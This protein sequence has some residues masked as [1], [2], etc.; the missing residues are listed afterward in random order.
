MGPS[1]LENKQLV[2]QRGQKPH[3]G[4]NFWNSAVNDLDWNI[5]LFIV[6]YSRLVNFLNLVKIIINL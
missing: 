6:K 1:F 5:A 4:F 2:S 3:L